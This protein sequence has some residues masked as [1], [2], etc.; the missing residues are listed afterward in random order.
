MNNKI[1]ALSIAVISLLSLQPTY[2]YAM[3]INHKPILDTNHTAE[4]SLD[5]FGE[6][7]G[8]QTCKNCR[9]IETTLILNENKTY[10]LK[11]TYIYANNHKKT[12]VS[13]G[14][15]KFNTEHT[16]IITLNIYGKK[17]LFFI[18]ENTATP[19]NTKGKNIKGATALKKMS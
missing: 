8:T 17:R 5:W 13:K 9:S 15:F 14:N 10:R 12:I 19:L 6:Y 7:I 4:N 16:S 18:G 11:E 3:D 2:S 1:C